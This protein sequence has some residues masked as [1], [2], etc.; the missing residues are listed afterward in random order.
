MPRYNDYRFMRRD[1]GGRNVVAEYEA[2]IQSWRQMM[3]G[4]LRDADGWL[5]L[6]GL[7]W[8]NPGNNS[9]GSGT[10]CD[11][12]LPASAPALLGSILFHHN[13]AELQITADLH[14]EV[15]H[16]PVQTA[17]LRND[18]DAHGAS[19]VSIGTISFTVIKRADQ[20]GIRVRDSASPERESFTG[21]IWYPINPAYKVTGTFE[22]HAEPRILQIDSSAGV[23]LPTENPGWAKFELDGQPVHLEAFSSKPDEVWFVF[24]DATSKG[25]ETYPAGRFV[26]A[27][28]HEDG[29]V[30]ID[31]NKAYSP[32]CAFTP[33]ATCPLP[34]KDNVLSVRIA[35]GEKAQPGGG[36]S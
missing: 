35:A 11:I 31:F 7:Y 15:D 22:R 27:P 4:R 26:Y 10:S 29:T 33:Y 18:H 32:P 2:E 6:T 17:V 21:R 28:L 34:P 9:I 30:E 8:L 5:T 1:T 19:V 36:H 20:Y 23:L 3:E 12:Q 16:V 25:G 24:R 13:M 14:V